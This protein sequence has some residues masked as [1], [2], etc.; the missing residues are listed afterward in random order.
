MISRKSGRF[1]TQILWPKP[2]TA[3]TKRREEDKGKKGNVNISE[4][5]ATSRAKKQVYR[6]E[7]WLR[8]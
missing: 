2:Y 3:D 1:R 5:F 7:R 8:V 4:Y 6:N